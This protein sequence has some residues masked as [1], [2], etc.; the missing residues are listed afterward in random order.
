[1]DGVPALRRECCHR[2]SHFAVSDYR[3]T[4]KVRC[5]FC[6][7]GT[8]VTKGTKYILCVLRVFVVSIQQDPKNS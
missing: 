5:I 3:D 1:M 2:F 4:H 7:E 6:H 8:K